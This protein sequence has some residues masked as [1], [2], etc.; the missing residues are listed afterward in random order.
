M[1]ITKNRLGPSDSRGKDGGVSGRREENLLKKK[2]GEKKLQQPV[3]GNE[4]T[5]PKVSTQ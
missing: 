1:A 2:T 3:D 4:K 5:K